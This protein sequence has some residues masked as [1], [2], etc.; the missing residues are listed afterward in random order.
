MAKEVFQCAPPSSILRRKGKVEKGMYLEVSNTAIFGVGLIYSEN[1]RNEYTSDINYSINTITKVEQGLYFDVDTLIIYIRT[2]S[3]YGVEKLQIR[4]PGLRDS[5]RATKLLR[6]LIEANKDDVV[7]QTKPMN[8]PRPISRPEIKD[9]VRK[10]ETEEKIARPEPAK[11][12]TPAP[13]PAPAPA[14]ASAPTPVAAPTPSPAPAAPT[15]V[16]PTPVAAQEDE[17]K[18][19]SNSITLEEYQ[20]KLAKLET[21]YLTGMV[22]EKEYKTRKAEYI[23]S[24]NG[25]DDFFNKVKVNL[26]YSE[27][28]FLSEKE[29]ADFKKNTVAECSELFNVSNDVLRQNLKKLFLLYL[30]EILSSEEYDK[31]CDDITESVQYVTTDSEETII[32]KIEKWPILKECEI[33]SEAQYEQFLKLIT[34]D[35]K[36]SPGDSIPVLEHKLVRMMT[37][38]KTFIYIDDEFERHKNDIVSEMTSFDFTNEARLRSQIEKMMLLRKCAWMSESEYAAKKAEVLRSIESNTDMVARMQLLGLLTEIKFIGKSD[39]DSYKS[40]LVNEIFSNLGD[41]SELK[42]KA[43]SLMNLKEAGIISPQEFDEYKKKLMSF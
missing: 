20:K 11:A 23:S 17:S 29:F 19:T 10:E 8:I 28:G 37:L 16:A 42:E 40:K 27:I 22:S 5:D 24:L 26:Q 34:E 6:K 1:S 38:S 4:F 2:T 33:I 13:A 36:F 21:I 41:I 35:T 30:T 9:E 39:Y 3:L 7:N 18:S 12:P 43:Q 32:N 25:L 14:S 31:I 15:P